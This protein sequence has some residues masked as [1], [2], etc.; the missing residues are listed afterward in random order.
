M[1][2]KRRPPGALEH[3]GS[4][5]HLS[6]DPR[7]PP[8]Q[9]PHKENTIQVSNKNHQWHPVASGPNCHPLGRLV[10]W[11]VGPAPSAAAG[12]AR[13]SRSTGRRVPGGSERQQPLTQ[14]GVVSLQVGDD[15]SLLFDDVF[16]A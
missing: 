13:P 10:R 11:S 1:C 9:Q 8:A 2:K 3:P 6:G 12:L 14:Q 4:V 15:V 7:V 5:K 16:Q